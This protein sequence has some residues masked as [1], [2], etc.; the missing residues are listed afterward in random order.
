MYIIT[1][2]LSVALGDFL[3]G[4]YQ[5]FCSETCL[6]KDNYKLTIRFHILQLIDFLKNMYVKSYSIR[7]IY[8]E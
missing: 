4:D 1:Y 3:A 5:Y 2:A 7:I 6:E 8:D